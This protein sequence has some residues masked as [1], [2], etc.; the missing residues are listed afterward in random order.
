M[1]VIAVVAAAALLGGCLTNTYKIPSTELQRL[2][3]TPPE[4]RA[5]HVRVIQEFEGESPPTQP[6]VGGETEI[7]FV[8][9]TVIVVGDGR[10]HH[11]SGGRGGGGKLGGGGGGGGGGDGKG[12]VILLVAMAAGAGIVLAATEGNRFDGWVRLHPMHPVH[13]W[14]PWG[15]GVVPLAQLDPNTAAV[16]TKAVI[17]DVEGPWLRLDR[18]P[19]D[20]QGFTYSVLGGAGEI[21]G[22]DGRGVGPQFHIQFGYYPVHQLGIQLAWTPAWRDDAMGDTILDIRLGL[23]VDLMPLDAGKLHGGGYG[24]ASI[25]WR[26]SSTGTEEAGFTG[27]GVKLQYELT[28]RLAITG[29]F[30]ITRAYNE[31]ARDATVGLSIY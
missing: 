29:R 10:H 9:R 14:G 24:N 15:Y 23:E 31:M 4:A 25:G 13:L 1:R 21:D 8:P 2:A 7:I 5:D 26:T 19:L 17:R 20:R 30:G 11:G 18:A 16:A 22:P 3:M 27:G 6:R 28:T 12:A